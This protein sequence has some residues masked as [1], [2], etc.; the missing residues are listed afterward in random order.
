MTFLV[1]TSNRFSKVNLQVTLP[2]VPPFV[3]GLLPTDGSETS[4]TIAKIHYKIPDLA[5]QFNHK[6]IEITASQY[7]FFMSLEKNILASKLTSC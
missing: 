6:H 1:S 3:L 5:K 7:S 4:V 2:Q